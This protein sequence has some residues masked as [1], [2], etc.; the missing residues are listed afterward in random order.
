MASVHGLNCALYWGYEA[1]YGTPVV[2]N[3]ALPPS[4]DNSIGA[5]DAV[6]IRPIYGDQSI[7]GIGGIE[8]ITPGMTNVEW[9]FS[10]NSINDPRFL[11]L[12]SQRGCVSPAGGTN[13]PLDR[14][15]WFTLA[16]GFHTGAPGSSTTRSI[17]VQD[18]KLNTVDLTY[19]FQ[20]PLR[21]RYAGFG[22]EIFRYSPEP[23][24]VSQSYA[25]KVSYQW[26]NATIDLV[27][28]TDHVSQIGSLADL[29]VRSGDIS[30]NHNITPEG[31]IQRPGE[32][33]G[34]QILRGWDDLEEAEPTV[35]GNFVCKNPLSLDNWN[36]QSPCPLDE[37]ETLL[38]FR[39]LCDY[40]H[41]LTIHVLNC[42]FESNEWTGP[43]RDRA[44][45]NIPY[46][47]RSPYFLIEYHD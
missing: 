17:V 6:S 20:E 39:D 44:I 41:C 37:F 38:T 15:A 18:C 9:S 25:D 16:F 23:T 21:V 2:F 40:T 24:T 28:P 33:G 4:A 1:S 35:R 13:D 14:L 10:N 3:L 32:T 46:V 5:I 43:A 29:I 34:R 26:Y 11:A 19:G 42:R 45:F 27:D 7:Y 8:D 36:M 22:G 31:W 30:I 47:S 12:A